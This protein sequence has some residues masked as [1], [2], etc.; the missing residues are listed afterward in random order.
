MTADAEAVLKKL[1]RLP[2]PR[3]AHAIADQTELLCIANLDGEITLADLASVL[4]RQHELEDVNQEDEG[5]PSAVVGLTVSDAYR[6]KASDVYR[7][8]S[9]RAGQFGEDY[10]FSLSDDGDIL[11]RR[12]D[13]LDPGQALYVFLLLAANLHRVC[14]G[15]QKVLTNGFEVLSLAAIRQYLPDNAVAHLFSNNP[16]VDDGPYPTKI[17]EKLEKLAEDLFETLVPTDDQFSKFNTGDRG[18]DVVAWIPFEDDTCGFIVLYGQ[19]ACTPKWVEKQHSVSEDRWS[20][21]INLTARQNSFCFIP[22]CYR[23]ADGGW[24]N[25]GLEIAKTVLVDRLRLIGLLRGSSLEEL[26]VPSTVV[27]D[28]WT[29]R[30]SA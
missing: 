26:L 23:D 28:V 15:H 9:A 30:E 7:V 8:L 29:F 13:D 17:F 24:F 22:Y 2:E 5:A 19:C 20:R 14:D 1:R 11:R 6:Q 12:G 4:A 10:P 27:D 21:V 18:I 16:L 25:G 3:D